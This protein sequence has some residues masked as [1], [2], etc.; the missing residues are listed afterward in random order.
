VSA[1]R[2]LTSG[3]AGPD[4]AAVDSIDEIRAALAQLQ[5]QAAMANA[6]AAQATATA[7]AATEEARRLRILAEQYGPALADGVQ[8]GGTGVEAIGAQAGNAVNTAD[9]LGGSIDRAGVGIDR[10]GAGL[11]RAARAAESVSSSTGEVVAG[12][13]LVALGIGLAVGV[14]YL[15]SAPEPRRKKKKKASE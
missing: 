14:T 5:Q 9:R 8:R 1:A 15:A 6:T 12:V 7:A 11:D 13:G 10:A 3:A 4:T 2:P